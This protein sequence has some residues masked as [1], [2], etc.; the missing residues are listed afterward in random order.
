MVVS[1]R[2]FVKFAQK[3]FGGYDAQLVLHLIVIP[4]LAF[5]AITT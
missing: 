3:T 2:L 5:F 1:K 4:I